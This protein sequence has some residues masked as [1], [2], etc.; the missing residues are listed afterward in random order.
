MTKTEVAEIQ[1]VLILILW[2]GYNK[3]KLFDLWLRSID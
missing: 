3:Y 1:L 2:L